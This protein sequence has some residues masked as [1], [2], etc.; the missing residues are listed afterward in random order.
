MAQ[1]ARAYRALPKNS[2][3]ISG[4]LQPHGTLALGDLMRFW[5]PWHLSSHVHTHTQ[6]YTRITNC[7]TCQ[8]LEILICMYFKR[9]GIAQCN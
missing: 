3:S 7:N 1:W 8:Y 9:N 4:R 5:T 6:A 2:S